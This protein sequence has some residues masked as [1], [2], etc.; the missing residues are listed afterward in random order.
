MRVQFCQ[1]IATRGSQ[2]NDPVAGLQSQGIVDLDRRD[3]RMQ[4]NFLRASVMY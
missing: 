3:F 4:R 2:R 1:G